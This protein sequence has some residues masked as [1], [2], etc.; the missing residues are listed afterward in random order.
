MA[1]RAWTRTAEGTEDLNP[2][3]LGGDEEGGAGTDRRRRWRHGGGA[4]PCAGGPA[5]LRARGRVGPPAAA[6]CPP[7]R[8]PVPCLET[9]RGRLPAAFEHWRLVGRAGPVG[10]GRSGRAGHGRRVWV[11]VCPRARC[12]PAD[13]PWPAGS[14]SAPPLGV[15]VAGSGSESPGPS[16]GLG[17]SRRRPGRVGSESESRG[18]GVPPL[19]S[20]G[21]S[22][23][24]YSA[25][26]WSG[27][28]GPVRRA[29]RCT[30]AGVCTS[31]RPR[32]DGGA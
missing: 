23:R 6:G 13:S 29:V 16:R 30:R 1:R 11:C 14:A 22:R 25:G 19:H 31:R 20:D 12:P 5:C 8:G 27:A 4:D 10:P 9:L 26:A 3:A 2:W 28:Y 15:R 21:P 18:S 32:A 17:P 24:R 7:G